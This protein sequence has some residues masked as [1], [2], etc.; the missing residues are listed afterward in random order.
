MSADSKSSGS[1]VSEL[2]SALQNE[3]KQLEANAEL[4]RSLRAQVKEL[5]EKNTHSSTAT[6]RVQ[7]MPCTVLC[8]SCL[9]EHETRVG[10]GQYCRAP[11]HRP[12]S[13]CS[14]RRSQ[15]SVLC[16][17]KSSA[18]HVKYVLFRSL[19]SLLAVYK[20]RSTLLS[21]EYC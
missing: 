8:F 20:T 18:S 3:R 19:H 1:R 21:Y 6:V 2:E 16:E 4:I 10:T 7:L 12:I 17:R 14:A 11:V 15:R 9:P 13:Y 5:S